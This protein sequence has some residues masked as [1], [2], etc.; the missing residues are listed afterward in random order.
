MYKYKEYVWSRKQK[1]WEIVDRTY[2]S[3]K[4]VAVVF[5]R[6]FTRCFQMP[7]VSAF[8]RNFSRGSANT[9]WERTL[10]TFSSVVAVFWVEGRDRKKRAISTA[11]RSFISLC[12]VSP[13]NMNYRPILLFFH[14]SKIRGHLHT[15]STL[16]PHFHTRSNQNYD[17]NSTIVVKNQSRQCIFSY[18][19]LIYIT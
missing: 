8:L 15:L 4:R 10:T 1:C 17:T 16:S 5:W 6:R 11:N 19:T 14:F 7:T 13:K 18:I 3:Q 9:K 12:D 2:E